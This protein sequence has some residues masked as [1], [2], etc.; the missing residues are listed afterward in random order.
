MSSIRRQG[1][2]SSL[3]IYFGFG[4]GLLNIYLFTK[5]G[6]FL[7]EQYG[8]YNAFIAIAMT[9]MAFANFAMPSFIYKFYPYYT[10]HLPPKKN[11]QATIALIVGLAGFAIILTAGIIFKGLVVR[12]YITNAPEIVTYYYWI[13]PLGF[14]LLVYTILEAYAWQLHKSVLTNFLREACWRIFTTVLITLFATGV[15]GSFDLFIKL[16]SLSYPFIALLLLFY[17]LFTGKIHFTF[18]LSKVSKKFAGNIIRLCSFVYAGSLVFTISLVFD[19]LVISS[20]L[21]DALAKLAVYSVAQNISAMIQVPQRGI[22][23]ASV[24]HLSR[25]WKEKNMH[26]IQRI[27]QR[28]AINQLIFSIAI[29]SLVVLN[30]TDAVITFNLKGTYLEAFYVV[31]FLG[32]AKVIDMGTG[33][34]AQVI[35]TSTRWRF[36]MV[37]GVILLLVMM[38]LCYFL[39][40]EYGIVGTGLANLISITVYNVVR[41]MFLWRT[42]NLFPFTMHTVHTVLLG[43]VCYVACYFIFRDLHGWAGLFARSISFIVLFGTGA[44]YFRLSP[45]IIPVA[46]SIGRRLGIV[47]AQ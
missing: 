26:L 32:L 10:D 18:R 43:A 39:T 13:F 6:L 36:E 7:D 25:A 33:L 19:S 45:D 44:V 11:D 5:Q 35:A 28:S 20:V 22:I 24:A 38:P 37:S 17:L 42:F 40:R 12:K 3:V 29:F 23:A 15:I 2:I 21:D 9:M 16:F 34:N 8:L 4:I 31:V 30:L 14:G 41:V 47:R 27:Y 46:K 1:I